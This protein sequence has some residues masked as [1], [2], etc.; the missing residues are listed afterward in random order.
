MLQKT[1]LGCYICCNDNIQKYISSVQMM[2][3][4]CI[5]IKYLK[6]MF[7]VFQVFHTYVVSVLSGCYKT[8]SGCCIYC[9]GYTHNVSSVCFKCFVR[10]S[11]ILQVFQLDASKVDMGEDTK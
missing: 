2:L 8:R 9:Y 1:D 7:Q 11:R 3:R 4:K 5:W 10:F 6:H